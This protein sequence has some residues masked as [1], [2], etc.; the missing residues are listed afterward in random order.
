MKVDI[1]YCEQLLQQTIVASIF[2]VKLVTRDA[3]DIRYPILSGI[4]LLP[5][6]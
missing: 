6:V 2:N 4:F 3:P 5:T 1:F